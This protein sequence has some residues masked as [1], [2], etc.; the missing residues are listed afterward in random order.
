MEKKKQKKWTIAKIILIMAF[1]FP[2]ANAN[3]ANAG[4]LGE[5]AYYATV[6]NLYQGYSQY[7]SALALLSGDYTYLYAAY[8]FMWYAV[9]NILDAE[10]Y[11]YYGT[12]PYA[13]PAWEYCV[14]A[15]DYLIIAEDYAWNAYDY[16]SSADSMWAI[17]YG[18]LGSF[19]AAIAEYYAA[20]GSN[21]GVY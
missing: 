14:S 5:S 7:Y 8:D 3:V 16:Y 20:I 19:D 11:A 15:Y 4:D 6:A 21:G 18:G 12:G 9:E 17:A 2:V 1:L 13:Y 10:Y